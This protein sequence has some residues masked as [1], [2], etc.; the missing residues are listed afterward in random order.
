MTKVFNIPSMSSL[1]EETRQ[2]YYPKEL[3][4]LSFGAVLKQPVYSHLGSVFTTET[5]YCL[6]RKD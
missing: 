6:E 2:L 5:K 1:T 4:Y 3:K